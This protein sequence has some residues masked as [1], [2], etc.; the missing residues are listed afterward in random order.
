MSERKEAVHSGY[1]IANRKWSLQ[2]QLEMG[3]HT[4]G[5]TAVEAWQRHIHMGGHS[6]SDFSI[7]VQRWSDKGYGPVAVEVRASPREREQ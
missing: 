5:R 2:V 4:F 3:A 7:F 1:I 6:R